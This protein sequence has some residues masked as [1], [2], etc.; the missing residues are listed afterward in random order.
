MT[1]KAKDNYLVNN[2]Q[3]QG[4]RSFGTNIPSGETFGKI[5][6]NNGLYQGIQ[7]DRNNGEILSQLK[8]NPYTLSVVNGI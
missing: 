8:S 7:A 1:M 6:G 5:N 2:R 4:D 3:Q